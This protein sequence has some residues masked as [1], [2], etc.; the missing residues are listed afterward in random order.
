M[1]ESFEIDFSDPVPLFPLPNCVLLPH[2]TIPL[3]IFEPRYRRMV[4]DALEGNG[5]IAMA[6]FS[7][8]DWKQ[9]YEGSPQLRRHVCLGA[10]VRH[11]K[12]ADGRYHLLLQGLC[13]ARTVREVTEPG[14]EYR[15]A[16]VEPTEG[17]ETMEIDLM[18]QRHRID[19]LLGDDLLR[20]LSAVNTIH[21]WLSPDLPTPALVDLAS[22]ALC[23]NSDQRYELLAQPDINTRARWL[24][25]QLRDPRRTLGIAERFRPADHP[26]GV[27]LN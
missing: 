2:A 4:A 6:L 25:R 27:T 9:D 24:E 26:D 5:V 22:M 11:E 21:N 7:G 13:R 3:H 1:S 14:D 20:K 23:E 8:E 16:V 18:E 10:I 19:E 12:L 17:D 15:K